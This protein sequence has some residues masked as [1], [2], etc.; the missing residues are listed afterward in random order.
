MDPSDLLVSAVESTTLASVA[1]DAPAQRL[2][3]QFRSRAVYCYSG[4]SLLVYQGL[5]TASS[6]GQYFNRNI[7]GRFPYH[8]Q[9]DC[10][11]QLVAMRPETPD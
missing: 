4:V 2:W 10:S 11:H 5:L 7:R 3:L 6:K 1:Y 8:K 9:S